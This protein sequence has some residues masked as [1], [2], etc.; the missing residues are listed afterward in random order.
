MLIAPERFW[1]AS[2]ITL[3]DLVEIGG[4]VETA[5]DGDVKHV[6]IGRTQKPYRFF[7]PFD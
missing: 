6:H 1:G 2:R 7:D 5:G 3:E 4:V